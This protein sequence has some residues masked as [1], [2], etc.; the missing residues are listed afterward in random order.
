[1]GREILCKL[2]SE[3]ASTHDHLLFVKVCLLVVIPV[4]GVTRIAIV[5]VIE[6]SLM[7][8]V[9]GRRRRYKPSPWPMTEAWRRQDWCRLQREQWLAIARAERERARDLP[10]PECGNLML[11]SEHGFHYCAYERGGMH[12]RARDF[13]AR[14]LIA[15]ALIG[16]EDGKQSISVP[17]T[18]VRRR[19]H[20]LRRAAEYRRS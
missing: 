4:K 2:R 17:R 20:V 6:L 18:Q 1:M 19:A 16:G 12:E 15:A 13:A 11:V 7:T 9:D 14:A 5:G 8:K 3:P 10:C